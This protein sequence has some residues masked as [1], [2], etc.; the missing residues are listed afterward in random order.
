MFKRLLSRLF[1]S[2]PKHARPWLGDPIPGLPTRNDD[3]TAV[4]EAVGVLHNDE[5]VEEPVDYL[6]TGYQPVVEFDCL[7]VHPCVREEFTDIALVGL[8][9][10]WSRER[11][12]KS[13]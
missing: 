1:P 3:L 5:P 7:P 10:K 9:D 8:L 4:A 6:P 12:E 11:R 13:S 2:A